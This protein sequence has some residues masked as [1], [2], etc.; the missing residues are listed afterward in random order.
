M[1]FHNKEERTLSAAYKFY[2]SKSQENS[3][4]AEAHIT[5]TYEILEAQLEKYKA[6]EKANKK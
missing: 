5:A 3:H 2:C 4:S 6:D 1:I